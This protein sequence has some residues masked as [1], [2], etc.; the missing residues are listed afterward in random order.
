VFRCERR[1]KVSQLSD[2]D[3]SPALGRRFRHGLVVGKF[4]PLHAGHLALI[5]NAM[6]T[7]ARVTVEVIGASTESVPVSIRAQWI[8]AEQPAVRVTQRVDDSEIDFDSSTAWDHHMGVIRDLLDPTDGPVDAVFTS[9]SYGGELARRLAAEWVQIDPTRSTVPVSGTAVRADIAGYWWALPAAVRAYFC[10]R[11]VVVGAESTGTTT[12]ATALAEHYQTTC[13]PEYGRTWTEIRPGGL[14]AP[15]QSSEFDLVAAE[16]ARLEDAAAG[17]AR[18][19]VIIADTDVLATAI[20]HE[21]YVGFSSPALNAFAGERV[22]D[23]YILTDCDIPFV[24][25]GMR[26]GEHIREWMDGRFRDELAAQPAPWLSVG[27]TLED[28][29]TRA[30]KDIDR[31]IGRGWDVAPSLEQQQATA[32]GGYTR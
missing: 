29:L 1:R 28:R 19:P 23:L 26:D 16:Q 2:A 22:P 3:G 4:Y 11:V 20:W 30:I 14:T 25:D 27:G 17:A 10:R 21:R 9:D 24:D 12:L 31:M 8:T 18:V 32:L 15:W 7:C 6:T 5:R 13:V